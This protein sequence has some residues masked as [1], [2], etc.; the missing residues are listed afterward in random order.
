MDKVLGKHIIAELWVRDPRRLDD[1]KLIR[2]ALTAASERGRFTVLNVSTHAFAPPRRHRDRAPFRVP[3][4]D[5]YLA[6]ACLCRGRHLHLRRIAPPGSHGAAT[7]A[8]CRAN[9]KSENWIAAS[10]DRAH[11]GRH[12]LLGIDEWIFRKRSEFQEVAIATVPGYGRG[13]F[14]DSV[15]EFLEAD[16]FVYHESLA[17]PPLLFH[18]APKRVLIEGGGDGLTLREVLRDP[19]V[20][21]VVMVELDPLVIDACKAHLAPLHRGSFD[22]P[23]A[24]I[25]VQDV[26]PYLE[27]LEQAFDVILVDL[28]D[29]YHE[30][31]VNLYD[32]VLALS[33]SALAPGGI[34]GAFG[35]LATPHM[36][37]RLVRRGLGK[38]FGHVV[39]H[40]ATIETFAGGYGF[41]LASNDVA[42]MDSATDDV[43]ARAASLDGELRAVVPELFPVC[44]RVAAHLRDALE[45]APPPVPRSLDTRFG[46]LDR[47]PASRSLVSDRRGSER[48]RGSSG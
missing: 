14:L 8:R 42:F 43:V 39:M 26:F 41:F 2:D 21:E 22:D 18:P 3:Y 37:A 10:W 24:T 23:R 17:L 31:A 20:E 38:T 4:V 35:D 48:D 7:E 6:G 30:L 28:L 13:L 5:P 25:L 15:V 45:A 36:P 1:E 47:G 44:F 11:P 19:R 32:R 12:I 40:T 29:G 9:G 27:R 16:E 34:V 33:A 46:W